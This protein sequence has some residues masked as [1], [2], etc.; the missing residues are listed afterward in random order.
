MPDVLAPADDPIGERDIGRAARK[1][2]YLEAR[3]AL[4]ANIEPAAFALTRD[5]NAIVAAL[6]LRRAEIL[7]P[8]LRAFHAI[9][10]ALRSVGK[11]HRGALRAV[12]REVAGDD[13]VALEKAGE[14]IWVGGL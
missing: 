5:E 12:H 6:E 4:A 1:L 11:R 14:G 13:D 10:R 3:G 2:A 9:E 8:K 7:E